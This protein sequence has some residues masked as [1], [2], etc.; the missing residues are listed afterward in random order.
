M[1]HSGFRQNAAFGEYQSW[2]QTIFS[3]HTNRTISIISLMDCAFYF[4]QN[5]P[6]RLT[7]SEMENDFP[8]EQS[9]FQAEHPFAESNFRLSRNLTLYEAFQNLFAQPQDSPVQ[10]PDSMDLTVFDMFILI[11]GMQHRI[12][13]DELTLT[14]AAQF[15]LPS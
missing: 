12:V 13:F 8:C 14:C 6:Y 7:T 3:N 9:I 10:T 2:A 1:K 4:Y 15:Y 11:H 5:Y